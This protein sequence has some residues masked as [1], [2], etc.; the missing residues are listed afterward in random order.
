MRLKGER[1]ER[2]E[3]LFISDDELEEERGFNIILLVEIKRSNVLIHIYNYID[4]ETHDG[5]MCYV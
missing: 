5:G 3:K 1:K 4:I 2:K